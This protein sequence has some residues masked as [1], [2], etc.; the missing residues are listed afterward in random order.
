MVGKK[1]PVT[2][3]LQNTWKFVLQYLQTLVC[4]RLD[5]N[6]NKLWPEKFYSRSFEPKFETQFKLKFELLFKLKLEGKF[7]LKLERKQL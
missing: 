4:R 2:G 1:R 3:P 5:Y 6:L 7:K